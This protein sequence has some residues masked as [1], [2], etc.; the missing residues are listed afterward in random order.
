V[1]RGDVV[2]TAAFAHT[3][4]ASGSDRR[5]T[6]DARIVERDRLMLCS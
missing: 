5:K 6:L 1:N 3:V 2:I 4:G